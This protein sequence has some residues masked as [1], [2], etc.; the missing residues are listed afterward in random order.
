MW[1][2]LVVATL[3]SASPDPTV[4]PAQPAPTPAPATPAAPTRVDAPDATRLPDGTFEGALT[5]APVDMTLHLTVVAGLVTRFEARRPDG[6]VFTLRPNGSPGDTGLRFG[7]RDEGS[8]VSVSGAFWDP[9]HAA[10]RFEGTLDKR[11]MSGTW[12][13]DRR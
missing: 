12:R 5:G 3:L 6:K 9:E 2:S 4:A 13:L 10:G 11:R 7:G 1:S 8:F